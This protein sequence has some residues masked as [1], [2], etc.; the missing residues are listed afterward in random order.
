MDGVAIL[1]DNWSLDSKTENVAWLPLYSVPVET[2]Y[3]NS[4]EHMVKLGVLEPLKPGFYVLHDDS[5]LQARRKDEVSSY[6]PFVIVDSNSD[7]DMWQIGASTCFA[8]LF[9]KYDKVGSET[10]QD[11]SAAIRACAEL[12]HLSARLNE[13]DDNR[14]KLGRQMLFLAGLSHRFGRDIEQRMFDQM[15]AHG[16]ALDVWFWKHS[17]LNILSRL[18]QVVRRLQVNA[19]SN[20]NTPYAEFLPSLYAYY[21]GVTNPA[22][23]GLEALFWVPFSVLKADDAALRSL[24]TKIIT[25][26][27]WQILLVSLLGAIEYKSLKAFASQSKENAAWLKSVELDIPASFREMAD[28]IEVQETRSTSVLGPFITRNVAE[29]EVGALVQK[30]TSNTKAVDACRRDLERRVGKMNATVVVD[31][32]LEN[33]LGVHN[34]I[35]ITDPFAN[36]RRTSRPLF[37]AEFAQ[38]TKQAFSSL[39][40]RPSLEM[41]KHVSFAFTMNGQ[42]TAPWLV[43]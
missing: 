10:K 39:V 25:N 3:L 2:H 19:D 32:N 20:A 35:V 4:S 24:Y 27:R 13:S 37:D 42:T 6:Y 23:Q 5:F 14:A 1:P 28:L 43:Q 36:Q 41:E 31:I 38:C 12:Q 11:D 8:E 9:K 29:E 26:E 21:L 40:G 30:I 17:K 22:Q 15:S 18:D 7:E 33:A 16:E 34:N